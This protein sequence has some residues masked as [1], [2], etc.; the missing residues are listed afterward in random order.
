MHG[1]QCLR[2]KIKKFP[3]KSLVYGMDVGELEFTKD[4]SQ[5]KVTKRHVAVLLCLTANGTILLTE[6]VRRFAQGKKMLC[7]K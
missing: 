7:V 3:E 5:C 2:E 6:E 4:F 1:D